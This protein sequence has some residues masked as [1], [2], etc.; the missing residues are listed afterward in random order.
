MELIINNYLA[1]KMDEFCIIL[2]EVAGS[3]RLRTE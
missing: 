2:R 3:L 1:N